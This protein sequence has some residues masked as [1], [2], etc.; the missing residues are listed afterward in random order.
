M[1]LAG[2]DMFE[3][4][5]DKYLEKE[6]QELFKRVMAQNLFISKQGRQDIQPI[7]AVLCTRVQ[8]STDKD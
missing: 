7:I 5:N 6:Q 2:Q 1:M 4:G 8:K 3:K